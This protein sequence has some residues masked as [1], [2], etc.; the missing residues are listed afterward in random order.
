[1]LNSVDKV[2]V[3]TCVAILSKLAAH[4]KGVSCFC[5]DNANHMIDAAK[6]AAMEPM[7]FQHL[8]HT[9]ENENSEVAIK[10]VESIGELLKYGRFVTSSV[11]HSS[12][13][14]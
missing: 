12:D 1:M 4:S 3:A 7:F 13:I 5:K 10:G 2:K 14:F 11:L 8:V 9:T 6:S